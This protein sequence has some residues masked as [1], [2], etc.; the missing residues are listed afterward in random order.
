MA[1]LYG[2]WQTIPYKTSLTEDGKIPV[3][4]NIATYNSFLESIWQHRDLQ[5]TI[6]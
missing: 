2:Y 1:D 6:T 4:S 5:W 3:V